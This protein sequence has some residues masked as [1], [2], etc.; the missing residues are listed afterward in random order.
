MLLLVKIVERLRKRNAATSSVKCW[1]KTTGLSVLRK[2]Q[3]NS[4]RKTAEKCRTAHSISAIFWRHPSVEIHGKCAYEGSHCSSKPPRLLFSHR[5]TNVFCSEMA[6][7]V[8]LSHPQDEGAKKGSK[9][10]PRE[11]LTIA[12]EVAA[13]HAH[14]ASY[15]SVKQ[16]FE[17]VA[18]R[19]HK[20]PHM[21]QKVT[22]KYVQD[23]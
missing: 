19:V 16:L 2:T 15:G 21:L 9:F 20:N 12:R 14:V 13:L 11:G 7:I 23:L 4:W 22:W 17:S 8:I 18:S 3:S 6:E 10:L 1:T 5:Q